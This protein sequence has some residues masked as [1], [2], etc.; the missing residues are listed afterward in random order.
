[1]AVVAW[2]GSFSG[3]QPPAEAPRVC[4]EGEAGLLVLRQAPLVAPPAALCAMVD[5]VG[6]RLNCCMARCCSAKGTRCTGV[7]APRLKK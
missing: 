1:L 7:A 5:A 4:A 2:D 6:C 3:R